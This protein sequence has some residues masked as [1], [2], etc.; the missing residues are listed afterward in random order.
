MKFPVLFAGPKFKDRPRFAQE[1][2]GRSWRQDH[3]D[4][5]WFRAIR[6]RRLDSSKA[7]S[8]FRT[9]KVRTRRRLHPKT[10]PQLFRSLA[11]S[12]CVR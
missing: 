11:R 7:P 3:R 5:V 9:P 1:A 10:S 4:E 2:T 12:I 8:P 6:I